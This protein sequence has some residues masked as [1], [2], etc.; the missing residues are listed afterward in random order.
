MPIDE[1]IIKI[2]LKAVL[3]LENASIRCDAYYQFNNTAFPPCPKCMVSTLGGFD[4]SNGFY[5]NFSCCI[6]LDFLYH[7]HIHRK[8]V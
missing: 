5:F 1:F 3:E 7:L 6:W 8:N 4:E 2:Y